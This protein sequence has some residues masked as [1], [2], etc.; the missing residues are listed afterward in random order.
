MKINNN[1]FHREIRSY[2]NKSIKH[3]L[4][5]NDNIELINIYTDGS[6]RY[7]KKH[8]AGYAFAIERV[9]HFYIKNGYTIIGKNKQKLGALYAETLA[10]RK[11]IEYA[12]KKNYRNIC[13]YTDNK[14]IINTLNANVEYINPILNSLINVI[15]NFLCLYIDFRLNIKYIQ[16]HSKIIGNELANLYAKKARKKDLITKSIDKYKINSYIKELNYVE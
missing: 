4:Y 15:C 7:T 5:N 2:E 3:L 11:A 10:I 16:G 13:I 9:D 6:F 1:I 8:I 14:Y 12:Y